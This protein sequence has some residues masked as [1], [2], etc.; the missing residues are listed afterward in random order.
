MSKQDQNV[1]RVCYIW[2]NYGLHNVCYTT[3]S[4]Y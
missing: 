4:L 2:M 3:I 1:S